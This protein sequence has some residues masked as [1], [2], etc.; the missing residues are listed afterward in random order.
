LGTTWNFLTQVCEPDV[1]VIPPGTGGSVCNVLGITFVGTA[2]GTGIGPT[3]NCSIV[4]VLLA[5]LQWFA[6]I[7]AVVAVVYGLRGGYLYITSGGDGDKLIEARKSIM[8]TMVGVIVALISFGII[9]IARAI[10]G[11]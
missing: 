5:L 1:I 6:W 9:A 7:I 4:A 8:Y 11:I 2:P 10:I 3:A